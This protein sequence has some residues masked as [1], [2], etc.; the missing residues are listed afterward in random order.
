M[1]L[2]SFLEEASKPW[3]AFSRDKSSRV[4]TRQS[5]RKRSAQTAA[6]GFW[7]ETD[8]YCWE[9]YNYGCR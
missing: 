9:I 5:W 4:L 6:E 3:T 7:S 2:K 1:H 8:L